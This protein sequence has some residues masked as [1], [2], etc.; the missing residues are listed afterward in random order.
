MYEVGISMVH[1]YYTGK[2]HL[3]SSLTNVA[4]HHKQLIQF[5]G[6]KCFLFDIR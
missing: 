6:L 3:S 4:C 2:E 1:R 5:V